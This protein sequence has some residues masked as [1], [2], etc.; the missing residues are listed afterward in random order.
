MFPASEPFPALTKEYGRKIPS[1]A[2]YLFGVSLSMIVPVNA[3]A[4]IVK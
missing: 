4:W 1:S 2:L 3:S